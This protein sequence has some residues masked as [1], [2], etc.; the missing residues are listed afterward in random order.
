MDQ[1]AVREGNDIMLRWLDHIDKSTEGVLSAE[2]IKNDKLKINKIGFSSRGRYLVVCFDRG[3]YL[4][5]GKELELKG[6]YPQ[7]SPVD[8]KFS[9]DERFMVTFNGN[10]VRSKEN[11]VIWGVEEEIKL[12]SYKA[13]L[14]QTLESFQF[15]S[16]S[17]LFAVASQHEI[18]IYNLDSIEQFKNQLRLSD[19]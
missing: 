15:N 6:F 9:A 2:Y 4:Y 14:G 18:F 3:T 19:E 5:G 10:D 8:F 11:F 12:K 7:E 1:F 13:F 17:T 16:K